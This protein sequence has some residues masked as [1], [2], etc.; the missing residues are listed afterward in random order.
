[1]QYICV[2]VCIYIYIYIYINVYILCLWMAR[3]SLCAENAVKHQANKHFPAETAVDVRMMAKR[4]CGLV[5]PFFQLAS[6]R[7]SPFWI[8]LQLRMMEVVV[9]TGKVCAV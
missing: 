1:M 4:V 7:M 3:Y 8:L 9:S 6:T 2:C 5:W